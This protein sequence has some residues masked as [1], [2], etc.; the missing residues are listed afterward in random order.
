MKDVT[1][2]SEQVKILKQARD[3]LKERYIASDFHKKREGQPQEAVPPS[4]EDE[5]IYKLLH[6]IHH[7]EKII[8]EIQAEQFELLKQQGQ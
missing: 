5:E 8:K 1:L 6:A 4:P 3:I 7:I 2:L